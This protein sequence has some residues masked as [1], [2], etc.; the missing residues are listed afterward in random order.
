MSDT[1]SSG[2]PRSPLS[3]L[4][5]RPSEPVTLTPPPEAEPHPGND[6]PPGPPAA[7]NRRKLDDAAR[8]LEH[9]AETGLKLDTALVSTIEAARDAF[10]RN[11]WTPAIAERFWPAYGALGDAVKPVT[12]ESLAACIGPDVKRALNWYRWMT[13]WLIV[14]IIPVSIV[15]FINTSISNEIADRIKE[16]DALAV[17]LRER[18]TTLRQAVAATT[19]AAPATDRDAITVLQQFATANRLLYGRADLLNKFILNTEHDPLDGLDKVARRAALE[20]PPRIQTQQVPDESLAKIETYQN[21]RAFAKA[22][23]QMNLMIYGAITAYMLPIIYALLGGCAYALRSI[24]EQTQAR[25]YRPSYAAFAR[26]SIALISGLVVGLFNN[27]TQ[28]VSLSPLAVAFLVGYA[29]E[30][31]FSFLDALLETLKKVRT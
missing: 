29:V 3:G 24:S 5:R 26:L 2:P 31:F 18:A 23:Q 12:A 9:A 11:A 10:A 20:I 21:I 14:T 17:T 6:P 22:T 16:S 8:L 25:T 30:V 1:G 13:I 27:F 19:T 4:I 28:S 15:M 7:V